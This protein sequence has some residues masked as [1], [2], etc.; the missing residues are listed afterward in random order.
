[1]EGIFASLRG[2]GAS[3]SM[4]LSY[5]RLRQFREV[6]TIGDYLQVIET[7]STPK[8]PLPVAPIAQPAPQ[9]LSSVLPKLDARVREASAPLFESG[10]FAH[11]VHEA[12]KAMRDMIR[13]VS[14][15]SDE[16]DTLAAKAFRSTNPIVPLFDLTSETGRSAQ[17]GVMLMAQGIFAAIR[18]PLAHDR[19]ALPQDQAEEMLSIINFVVRTLNERPAATQSGSDGT[20]TRDLRRDRPAL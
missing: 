11:A 15:L 1:M 8:P 18:N 17:R 7:R 3:W 6:R 2:E 10:H 13:E 5:D 16:G 4:D 12:T 9:P 19:G 20:R 14:G